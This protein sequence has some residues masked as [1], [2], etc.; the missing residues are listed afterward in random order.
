MWIKTQFLALRASE[1]KRLLV[2]CPC[3]I[4]HTLFISFSP[5]PY[6]HTEKPMAEQKLAQN[7]PSNCVSLFPQLLSAGPYSLHWLPSP[8]TGGL[9]A[10]HSFPGRRAQLLFPLCSSQGRDVSQMV[11][12]CTCPVPFLSSLLNKGSMGFCPAHLS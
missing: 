3:L 12:G 7:S 11:G 2:G 1:D 5:L 9:C 4:L 10:L 6:T 8:G